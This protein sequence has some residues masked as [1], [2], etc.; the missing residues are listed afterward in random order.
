MQSAGKDMHDVQFVQPV[1]LASSPL[2][3]VIAMYMHWHY[4]HPGIDRLMTLILQFVHIKHLRTLVKEIK[5][6][7][8]YCKIVSRKVLRTKI[9]NQSQLPMFKAPPFYAVQV[10]ICYNDQMVAFDVKRRVKKQVY[11]LVCVCMISHA[12]EIHA[13]DSMDTESIIFALERLAVRYGWPKYIL[14]DNQSSFKKL[15]D[16][17]VTFRDLQGRLFK[18]HNVSLDFSSP[19]AH[20]E[21]GKVEARVKIFKELMSTQCRFTSPLSYLEWETICARLAAQMNN[22][23]IGYYSVSENEVVDFI[24]PNLFILGRNNSR[25]MEGTPI[26]EDSPLTRI[27][28]LQDITL[29]LYQ[30]L[31][32]NLHRLVPG[33][34]PSRDDPIKVGDIVLFLHKEAIRSRN[35]DWKYGRI[36]AIQVDG[37]PYTV[38]VSY[39]NSG[40][41]VVRRVVRHHSQI[42]FIMDINDVQLNSYEHLKL[43]ISKLN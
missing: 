3:Y 39:T 9:L 23:P 20:Q 22:L 7:C 41:C 38:E 36:S 26:L 28:E 4:G 43:I 18:D 13:M 31:Y 19:L 25:A 11:I 17:Q 1:V 8:T 42:I 14:P 29:A 21:H 12:V 15:K 32:D 33:K 5:L 30:I 10:D 6:K 2:A 24:T 16:F 27:Q 37:R 40:E 35:N 34:T